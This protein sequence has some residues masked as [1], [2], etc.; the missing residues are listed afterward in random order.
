M[1]ITIAIAAIQRRFRCTPELY[2]CGARFACTVRMKY[3]VIAAA[4]VLLVACRRSSREDYS[5]NGPAQTSTTTAAGAPSRTSPVAPQ[6]EKRPSTRIAG[7]AAQTADVQLI[8][9]AIRMPQTFAP[10]KYTFN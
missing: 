7:P 10:G 9:Y 1:A 6:Q 2:G 5:Q 8:A 3:A 4:L